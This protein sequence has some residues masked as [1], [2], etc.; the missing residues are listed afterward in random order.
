MQYTM[1]IT[2]KGQATIPVAI[3]K[4]FGITPGKTAKINISLKPGHRTA[5][6]EKPITA[7]EVQRR[8]RQRLKPGIPPLLDARAFYNTR[9][10]HL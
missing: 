8:A 4:A 5:V 2:S 10:P 9:E 7:E 1:T 6:M 3:R